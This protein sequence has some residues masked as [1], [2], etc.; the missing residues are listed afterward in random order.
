MKSLFS[1]INMKGIVALTSCFEGLFSKAKRQ[2]MEKGS[3]FG[4]SRFVVSFQSQK[5]RDNG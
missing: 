3:L 1:P 4:P 2:M 5:F